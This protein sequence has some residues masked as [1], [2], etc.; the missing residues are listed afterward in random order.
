MLP[1]A[2]FANRTQATSVERSIYEVFSR[3]QYAL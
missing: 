3:F 1:W 2:D